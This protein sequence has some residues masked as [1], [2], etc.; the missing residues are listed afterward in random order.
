MRNICLTTSAAF[1]SFFSM[2]E[3]ADR[4]TLYNICVRIQALI[5]DFIVNDQETSTIETFIPLLSNLRL[6]S[7][8][9]FYENEEDRLQEVMKIARKAA[10]DVEGKLC[11]RVRWDTH[12][13]YPPSVSTFQL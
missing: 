7:M 10:R 5:I 4:H 9:I 11:L 13:S 2:I 12:E 6:L 1:L 3:Q 8:R